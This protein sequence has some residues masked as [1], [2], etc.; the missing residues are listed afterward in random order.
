MAWDNLVTYKEFSGSPYDISRTLTPGES[1]EYEITFTFANAKGGAVMDMNVFYRINNSDVM[2]F[3]VPRRTPT[4]PN[5]M[6]RRGKY[7]LI[8]HGVALPFHHDWKGVSEA[9]PAWEKA[10]HDTRSTRRRRSMS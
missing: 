5:V 4:N 8:D 6:V 3:P 1:K 10:R 9:S 7:W 2:G